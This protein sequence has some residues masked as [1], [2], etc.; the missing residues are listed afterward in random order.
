MIFL[1]FPEKSVF[2]K[3]LIAANLRCADWVCS[4]SEIMADQ[5][6]YINNVQNLKIIHFGI[7]VEKFKPL[8]NSKPLDTITIGT[9]KALTPIYGIDTLIFTFFYVKQYCDINLPEISQKLRL[10]IV[11]DGFQRNGLE[12]LVNRFNLQSLVTFTGVVSHVKV[13]YYLS[14]LDIY[15]AVSRCRESFGVA[16]LEASACEIPFIVSDLGTCPKWSKMESLV[17]WSKRKIP[18]LRHKQ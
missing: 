10:L 15:V 13:P 8:Y 7:D 4:T 1:Y 2:H 12:S 6:K 9:V 3:N 5:I 14:Q 16:V 17:M 11:G 18:K